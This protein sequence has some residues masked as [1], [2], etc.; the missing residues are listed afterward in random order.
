M[1]FVDPHDGCDDFNIEMEI[2]VWRNPMTYVAIAA[3]GVLI[4]LNI[5]A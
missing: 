2:R 1:I 3:I 4:L 5:F